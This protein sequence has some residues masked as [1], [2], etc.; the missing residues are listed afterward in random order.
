MVYRFVLVSD[1]NDFFKREILIDSEATFLELNDFIL[2]SVGYD[3]EE[4]TSFYLCD[5][6]WNKEQEVILMDMGQDSDEDVYLMEKT[7]LEELVDHRGQQIFFVFDLLSERGF[8]MELTEMI[9]GKSLDAPELTVSEGKAPER[10]ASL[11]VALS[12]TLVADPATLDGE[13]YESGFNEED[14]D[15]EGFDISDGENL[16]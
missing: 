2:S 14:I 11:D 4:L 15:L 12:R 13:D 16:Y 9:P 7:P 10:L 1:E 6:A 8:F 5:D 3:H